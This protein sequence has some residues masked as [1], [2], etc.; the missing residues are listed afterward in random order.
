M[1]RAMSLS[2]TLISMV[3][4]LTT[5]VSLRSNATEV[6]LSTWPSHGKNAG[7]Y[8]AERRGYYSDQGLTFSFVTSF[9][10]TL[11][12]LEA[13]DAE[14]A[15]VLCSDA[16][17]VINNGADYIIVGVR[18]A[19][20]PVGTISLR[21]LAIQT[22][23]DYA[24]RTWGHSAG[25][26]PEMAVLPWIARQRGFDVDSVKVIHLDFPARLPALLRREVDFISAWWE[27]DIQFRKL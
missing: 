20:F 1:S 8:L 26:S 9:Q 21:E 10:H 23:E 13:G 25:F 16:L 27:A 2:V 22:P 4:L 3:I 14:I 11:I 15:Q 12:P 6:R 7:F 24:N 17:K 19:Q 18:D 5:F